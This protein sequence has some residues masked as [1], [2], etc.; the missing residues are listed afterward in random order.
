MTYQ[1]ALKAIKT[2]S[3]F[4]QNFIITEE[5]VKEWALIIQEYEFRHVMENLKEHVKT[6]KFP[7][8]LS[9]LIAAKEVEKPIRHAGYLPNTAESMQISAEE[10]RRF[11]EALERPAISGGINFNK[12]ELKRMMDNLRSGE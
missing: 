5:K 8:N 9:D 11:L 3:V 12:A 4:Y 6:S 7:P 10:A 1:E 2:I